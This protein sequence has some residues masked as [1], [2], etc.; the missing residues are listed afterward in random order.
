[1][2]DC[3]FCEGTGRK[4]LNGSTEE[5]GCCITACQY[6]GGS[7]D[8]GELD[9]TLANNVKQFTGQPVSQYPKLGELASRLD[10]LFDEYAGEIPTMAAVGV[11]ESKKIVILLQGLDQ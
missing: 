8:A 6:C 9:L 5:F 1:M 2:T 7:G 10:D 4:A 3:S 11:L